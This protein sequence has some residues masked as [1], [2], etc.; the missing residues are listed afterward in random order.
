MKRAIVE[1]GFAQRGDCVFLDHEFKCRDYVGRHLEVPA[2]RSPIVQWNGKGRAEVRADAGIE[3][4]YGPIDEAFD[5]R[6]PGVAE[7]Q[8]VQQRRQRARFAFG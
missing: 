4:R 6:M 8:R 3:K 5:V 2:I 7:E 1:K